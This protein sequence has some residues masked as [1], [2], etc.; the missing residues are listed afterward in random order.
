MSKLILTGNGLDPKY[1]KLAKQ[2]LAQIEAGDFRLNEQIPSIKQLSKKFKMS[3]E[4]VAKALNLLSEQGIIKAV[5]RQ[6]YFVQKTEVKVGLRILFLMDKITEFKNQMYEAFL[7]TIGDQGEVHIF[8]HHHNYRFFNSLIKDNLKNYTHFVIVSFMQEDISST[9]NLIPPE[10]RVIL[11]C[12]E[13]QLEGD[14]TMVYQ[15]FAANVFNALSDARTLL[16][17]YRRLILVVPSDI[18]FFADVEKGF[19]EFVSE[20]GIPSK[21]CTSIQEEE[22][23]AG[24]AYFTFRATDDFDMVKVIKLCRAHNLIL[25]QEV[26]LITYN[27]TVVK[28]ILEGGITTVAINFKKMGELAAQKILN[29]SKDIEAVTSKL[30]LRN[31]L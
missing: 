12:R 2:L 29:K 31:S 30:I 20:M 6:G 5:H 21:I 27:D 1:K 14:Y 15:D 17:K 28:E 10:R 13:D 18:S 22:F 11:D 16:E 7:E 23:E 25:G 4:T 26:G 8:F 24:N 19:Q 3:R 9:L